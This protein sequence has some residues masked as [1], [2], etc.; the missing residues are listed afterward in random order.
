MMQALFLSYVLINIWDH[1][2]IED[3][4]INTN[5]LNSI[6]S[7]IRS[8]VKLFCYFSHVLSVRV[9]GF[10][11]YQWDNS[12]NLVQFIYPCFGKTNSGNSREFP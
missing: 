11:N 12:L 3:F 2:H 8:Q 10:D 6:L 1:G 4:K 9:M 5:I 7:V